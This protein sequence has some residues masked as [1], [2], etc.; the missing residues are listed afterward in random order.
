VDAGYEK[1]SWGWDSTAEGEEG[2]SECAEHFD[3]DIW[4]GGRDGNAEDE[5]L[6]EI[7][8]MGNIESEWLISICSG[9]MR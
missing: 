1:E 2:W 8:K 5:G 9:V 7:E 6:D 3:E 4:G